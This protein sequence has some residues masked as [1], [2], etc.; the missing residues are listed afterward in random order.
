MSQSEK[1]STSSTTRAD[2]PEVK[3]TAEDKKRKSENT[4]N[5]SDGEFDNP[6]RLNFET[7][8]PFANNE[9]I[10][11]LTP[12]QSMVKA[13]EKSIAG[14][15]TKLDN[16]I[17]KIDGLVREGEE[18]MEQLEQRVVALESRDETDWSPSPVVDLNVKLLGDSNYS[19]KVKIGMERGTLGSALPGASRFCPKVENLP[20]SEDLVDFTDIVLA[21]GT[22]DLTGLTPLLLPVPCILLLKNTVLIFPT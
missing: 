1:P 11:P 18:R 2:I 6:K 15:F 4:S 7:S 20:Q 3:V 10:I 16:I 5:I 22:N 13:M 9:D 12:E 14:V 17:N 8:S 19:G 21:V